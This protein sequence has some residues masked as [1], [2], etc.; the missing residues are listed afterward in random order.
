[1]YIHHLAFVRRGRH[2]TG[3]LSCLLLSI[4][5]HAQKLQLKGVVRDEQSKPIPAATVI[6]EPGHLEAITD[7]DGRFLFKSLYPG[8]YAITLNHVG[9]ANMDSSVV[10]KEDVVNIFDMALTPK[11]NALEDVQ[12]TGLDKA[13]APVP[14]NLI[15][16]ERS[17]MPVKVITRRMIELMGSRRL[18]E[19]LKEQTGMAIVNNIGGGSRSVGVQMQGFG[20]DYVM[21]LIDGQPMLGRNSGSFDLSRISV[22]NIERIEIIKGASSCLYGSEALGGAINIITKHGAVRPQ[23]LASVTYGTLN[24]K[25]ITV[26]G[27][28]P[29]YHQRGSVSLSGNYYH[30]DG[31]NTNP[32]LTS[33]TT[34][35]PYD[36]YSFQGRSR[37]Q[38]AQNS[39]V[40]VSARY[41]LRRSLMSK[42]WGDDLVSNDYQNEKDLNLSATFD[43]RFADGLRTMT[44]YYFT[45]YSTDESLRWTSSTA[46]TSQSVF[47]QNM[48]RAEQQFDKKWNEQLAFTGG[49]G[50]T[51]E[52]IK[53]QSSVGKRNQYTYF[54]YLQ[55]DWNPTKDLNFVGGVRYDRTRYYGGKVNPS[56]GVQYQVLPELRFKA[57]IGTGFKAPDFKMRYQIF[58]NPAANYLVIGS[59]MLTQTLAT[60][61]ENGEISETRTYIVQQLSQGLKPERSTSFNVGYLWQPKSIFKMETSVFYHKIYNQIDAVLVATGTSIDQ[62]FSYRNLPR[63]VNKG[64]ETSISVD[65]FSNLDIN[66]GYQYL[67]AKDL[68]VEDSIRA[69]HWPYSIPIYDA[70]TGNSYTPKPSDYWGIENRSR[71]MLNLKV[72]YTYQPWDLTANVRVNYRGKYP[73][74][75]Y[76]GNQFIDKYDIFVKSQ[77]L[78]NITFEKKLLNQHLSLRLSVDNL[79]DFKSMYIPGQPGR[80]ILGGVTYR[81]F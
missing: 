72:L 22:A 46:N 20:S 17:A 51:Y 39:I 24:I 30:T 61:R 23:G 58:Y 16:S 48:H 8:R 12:V 10:V 7:N 4:A 81:L 50:F 36:N 78:V 29:Y 11:A 45:R 38:L 18:D 40:G 56:F 62:I 76:N 79:L 31:F 70:A 49:L 69:G 21:I 65:P 42:D 74:G 1:M 71:H 25:D 47:T 73:F 41:G 32:Y 5:A 55:G 66:I 15:K 6:L 19:V 54:G 14:D 53:E 67:I 33:G 2:L 27:E 44:R 26:E 13:K 64:V 80:L 57:G 28:T 34:A 52:Q 77:T 59:D 63:A 37:Y 60:M 43:H 75:D 9:Y 68:S 3:L 35:P